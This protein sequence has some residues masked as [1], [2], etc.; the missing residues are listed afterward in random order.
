MS[1]RI[2]VRTI[3]IPRSVACPECGGP[4]IHAEGCRTGPL[5]GYSGCA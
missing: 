3:V 4:L 1:R 5:C 2:R